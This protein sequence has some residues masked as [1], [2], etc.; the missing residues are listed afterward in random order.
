MDIQ[1]THPIS[2]RKSVWDYTGEEIAR[3]LDMEQKLEDHNEAYARW[4]DDEEK[5]IRRIKNYPM[6]LQ[7]EALSRF[8][9]R[10]SAPLPPEQLSEL[11]DF[12][13]AVNR[14]AAAT[15]QSLHPKLRQIAEQAR[16]AR[17]AAGK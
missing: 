14:E 3:F 13:S 6:D 9:P 12:Q 11:R 7:R 10:P 8:R 5:L 1:K 16:N 17:K 15:M 4:R 2:S